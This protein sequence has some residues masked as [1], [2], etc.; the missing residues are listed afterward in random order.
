MQQQNPGGAQPIWRPMQISNPSTKLRQA[1]SMPHWVTRESPSS[2]V[3]PPPPPA[4]TAG[5]PPATTD[6]DYE[7]IE[8]AGGSQQ[9]SNTE[10]VFEKVRKSKTPGRCDLCGSSIPTVQC[11]QCPSQHFCASCDDMYH[12]HPKRQ[13]HARKSL[14]PVAP[15]LRPPLPPKGEAMSAPVAPPRKN[16]HSSARSSSSRFTPSPLSAQFQLSSST[17]TLK[18]EPSGLIGSLKRFMGGRPLPPPPHMLSRD[19]RMS[20]PA[21]QLKHNMDS[22]GPSSVDSGYLDWDSDRRTRSGSFS[23]INTMGP[24]FGGMGQAQSMAQ[25]NCP[26]CLHHPTPTMGGMGWNDWNSTLNLQ[27]PGGP[28]QAPGGWTTLGPQRHMNTWHGSQ[29]LAPAPFTPREEFSRRNSLRHSA[30]RSRRDS[31]SERSEYRHRDDARS[32]HPDS[33]S[34][35]ESFKRGSSKHSKHG[36]GR[37]S[38]AMSYRSRHPLSDI[39]S[40]GDTMSRKGGRRRG[41]RRNKSPIPSSPAMSRKSTRPSPP[42][43]RRGSR[44]QS[45]GGQSKLGRHRSKQTVSPTFSRKQLSSDSD[46]ERS[47]EPESK[48]RQATKTI[49]RQ[50]SRESGGGK[51]LMRSWSKSS[52]TKEP[53]PNESLSRVTSPTPIVPRKGGWEC[54][55]C[56]LVNPVGTTVC[57]VCCKTSNASLASKSSV[58]SEEDN[59][60]EGVKKLT[61]NEE[62]VKASEP[63]GN[64]QNNGNGLKKGRAQSVDYLGR[65]EVISTGTSPPPQSISTQTYDY[66]GG[67]GVGGVG[68]KRATSLADDVWRPIMSRPMSRQSTLDSHSMAC[69]PIPT[70]DIVAQ[71]R[72]DYEFHKFSRSLSQASQRISQDLPHQI[73]REAEQNGFTAEDLTIALSHCGESNPVTWLINNWRHMIDTVVTLATNYGHERSENN[74]GTLSAVE[75]R[76][77]LRLHNG[78]VW[79]AVTECVETRQKKFNDLMS[80]GNF[81]REDIVTVLT[82]NH[83]NVESAFVELN[84]TQLKPFLMRIWGPPQGLDN[85][86]GDVSRF[87]REEDEIATHANANGEVGSKEVSYTLDPYSDNAI[88]KHQR[89]KSMTELNQRSFYDN[90]MEESS[91]VISNIQLRK[92]KPLKSTISTIYSSNVDLR[93]NTEPLHYYQETP[94]QVENP[95]NY[96]PQTPDTRQAG[97]N[98]SIEY[99][100]EDDDESLTIRNTLH[101][102]YVAAI[103]SNETL[104]T[105]ETV[106]QIATN[107][108]DTV[109]QANVIKT[110]FVP[111][112]KMKFS[113]EAQERNQTAK[114]EPVSVLLKNVIQNTISTPEETQNS[115]NNLSIPTQTDLERESGK[116]TDLKYTNSFSGKNSKKPSVAKRKS[117]TR[118]IR[119][120]KKKV[121]SKLLG[122]KENEPDKEDTDTVQNVSS[123]NV[124]QVTQV[125]KPQTV[126]NNGSKDEPK[127]LSQ[128]EVLKTEPTKSIS[129]SQTI[130]KETKEITQKVPTNLEP[131]IIEP[132]R[133]TT[134]NEAVNQEPTKSSIQT[135]P[136]KHEPT[137]SS[138]KNE[139]IK[140]EPTKSAIQNEPVKPEPTKSNILNEPVKIEPTKNT[141]Q[142]EPVKSSEPTEIN[143]K[144]ETT[145]TAEKR[146]QEEGNRPP[147]NTEQSAKPKD[148]VVPKD[149]TSFLNDKVQNVK[150]NVLNTIQSLTNVLNTI[151]LTTNKESN[152]NSTQL[153]SNA[154]ETPVPSIELTTITNE[155]RKNVRPMKE[156]SQ[157]QNSNPMFQTKNT[158]N[159]VKH[160]RRNN[161]RNRKNKPNNNKIKDSITA[162]NTNCNQD[163]TKQEQSKS[164]PAKIINNTVKI[165]DVHLNN[166]KPKEKVTVEFEKD[167]IFVS[168]GE[169]HK[170]IIKP[171]IEKILESQSNNKN[172]KKEEMLLNVETVK[173]TN[174]ESID[175]AEINQK[176]PNKPELEILTNKNDAVK[177]ETPKIQDAIVTHT[178]VLNEETINRTDDKYNSVKTSEQG[179]VNTC[180][181]KKVEVE[182]SDEWEDEDGEEDAEQEGEEEEELEEEEEEEHMKE[183]TVTPKDNHSQIEKP[184]P[185]PEPEAIEPKIPPSALQTNV[186]NDR[187]LVE[188]DDDSQETEQNTEQDSKV[189]DE[190]NT[191]DE[192][193]D[194]SEDEEEVSETESPNI[195]TKHYVKPISQTKDNIATE[196]S[197][198][199]YIDAKDRSSSSSGKVESSTDENS[200]FLSVQSEFSQLETFLNEMSVPQPKTSNNL[201]KTIRTAQQVETVA[202]ENDVNTRKVED[203]KKAV[204][205]LTTKI[206]QIQLQENKMMSPS[207]T[208]DIESVLDVKIIA[209]N[210][211]FEQSKVG[212]KIESPPSTSSLSEKEMVLNT[213]RGDTSSS[214][215]I[216]S[217]ILDSSSR[218]DP[219]DIPQAKLPHHISTGHQS[220]NRTSDE[221]K[222]NMT[223]NKQEILELL[224]QSLSNE[225]VLEDIINKLFRSVMGETDVQNIPGTMENIAQFPK[226][227]DNLSY[228][229]ET[230]ASTTARKSNI[231][232]TTNEQIPQKP[233]EVDST[234]KVDVNDTSKVL[235]DSMNQNKRYAVYD[236]PLQPTVVPVDNVA[237]TLQSVSPVNVALSDF[238]REVRRCL[239]EGLVSNYEQAELAVKLMRMSFDQE[240]SVAAAKDCS[241]EQAALAYLQQECT[242]CAGKYPMGQ[243]V[244]MLECEHHCCND[245]ATAYF[246]LTITERSIN[247]CVCPF[248]SAPDLKAFNDDRALDYFSNLDI[249]LKTIVDEKAHELFQRKLRDRTLMQDPNFKWC[250]KCSSGFIADPRQK[251]FICP[252]CNSVSCAKCNRPWAK[253]HERKTCDEFSAWLELSDPNSSISRHLIENDGIVC[254]KCHSKYALAKGGCMHLTCPSCKYEFCSDCGQEFLM[255]TKCTV[256]PYC[257]KLGLH[258]HH[259]RNC[260]FYLRDKE[261]GELQQLLRD[262]GVEFKEGVSPDQRKCNVQ[263][264]REINGEL[265][266]SVCNLP[267]EGSTLCRRHYIEHLSR[268]ITEHKLECL[269]ILSTD[270]LETIVRRAGKRLPSRPYGTPVQ[271]FHNALLK[272]IQEEIPLY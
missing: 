235:I 256:S 114:E 24:G 157:A 197:D 98:D 158:I 131:V 240:L 1:R 56:T 111:Y 77:A 116:A 217:E 177:K 123:Q 188:S 238:E 6:P 185:E 11:D 151:P 91:T 115:S 118:S 263:L 186:E 231:I 267:V 45:P 239:A 62:E 178:A 101:N 73:I 54:E 241:T 75:A 81:T 272:I 182:D 154:T 52:K 170:L 224:R 209:P 250:T 22:K 7:V 37:V 271:T 141:I 173:Q 261:P 68:M 112:A 39:D 207:P 168:D 76:D 202:P 265:Q 65:T 55:H 266:D 153:V 171:Q 78:N 237:P 67:G 138:I 13:H 126:N 213:K 206:A 229:A 230:A 57:S 150:T 29:I 3:A 70:P 135:E 27:H 174:T 222:L 87:Q 93:I 59:L 189:L 71:D 36:G 137:I 148:S 242:L 172:E 192:Y 28:H 53:P 215:D 181:V 66:G 218:C 180:V 90:N 35:E 212:I 128:K 145:T 164:S 50:S 2:T 269:P 132:T 5:T 210:Q 48:Q 169:T 194:E 227:E 260:L 199:Q 14:G 95:I 198:D 33:S 203:K 127:K 9:Y 23:A 152:T 104:F 47:S 193:T 147:N 79:A 200:D 17:H 21:L 15:P 149:S 10:P 243:M 119:S 80:R 122:Q 234:M 18:K 58:A 190:T 86:S 183:K 136:V 19:S 121:K 251:K 105:N 214:A 264:Q 125:I 124:E 220:Q 129:S 140:Q 204:Q 225:T 72:A 42:M 41:G 31:S 195:I 221:T 253:E 49:E 244:S 34:D 110:A 43:S 252:D 134:Q 143:Q 69:S 255:G 88:V 38:P 163:A 64:Q 176:V 179:T 108:Q 270:D 83:G 232:I 12:R 187:E 236:L 117:I 40:E 233:T 254:P 268:L 89:S 99:I 223:E 61:V 130:E 216:S 96:H 228:S 113:G 201:N 211:L 245:C 246:T 8:F 103:V 97:V 32:R 165:T 142:N 106:N 63:N 133:S 74:V 4:P 258:S 30:R 191:G 262:A 92:D 16:K 205:I 84:K 82:A 219:R 20:Q 167:I 160:N 156:V 146:T 162:T 107:V 139:A 248:C 51:K 196:S 46:S 247:D 159:K 120:V 184:I 25:L 249:L 208:D 257:E 100:D 161:K 155:R 109:Q 44:A 259:P 175:N 85:D 60:D 166:D 144:I 26:S 102:E 226:T 94:R